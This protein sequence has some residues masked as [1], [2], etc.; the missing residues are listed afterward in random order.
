MLNQTRGAN[1]ETD[2]KGQFVIRRKGPIR[3][4]T[5]SESDEKGQFGI[6]RKGPIRNQMKRAS[7]VPNEHFL[8]CI[9]AKYKPFKLGKCCNYFRHVIV[10]SIKRS[11][12][13]IDFQIFTCNVCI[14]LQDTS[15]FCKCLVIYNHV[16]Y[17]KIE[18]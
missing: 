5:N 13:G 17:V 14:V 12:Y 8:A 7:C 4:Q 9:R 1:S 3:N 2:E 15:L 6:R 11:L 10:S 18:G 16:C